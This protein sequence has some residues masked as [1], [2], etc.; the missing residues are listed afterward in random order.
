MMEQSYCPQMKF[1]IQLD[2][3]WFTQWAG[4]GARVG[5][6]LLGLLRD[7]PGNPLSVFPVT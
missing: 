7:N 5:S 1:Y 2:S 3:N 6:P 4:V